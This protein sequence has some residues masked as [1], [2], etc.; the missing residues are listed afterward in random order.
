MTAPTSS[1]P[2]APGNTSGG[3]VQGGG[4]QGGGAPSTIGA[5]LVLLAELAGVDAKHRAISER[6]ESLPAAAR[7]ADDASS[8]LKKQLDDATAKKDAAEKARKAVETEIVDERA[9]MKKWE[10]RAQD[11]RGEREHAALVSEI[12][13]ARRV[14]SRLEDTQLEHM[15]AIEEATAVISAVAEQH[16][17]ASDDA[18]AEWAKVD[19]DLQKLKGEAAL[20]DTARQALLVKLPAPLV[21]RYETVAAKRQGVG[22]ALIQGDT[23]AC[24]KRTLPPQLCIQVRKG[25]VVEQCPSCSRFLVH[26]SMTAAAADGAAPTGGA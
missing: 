17:K 11:I 23:C 19:G 15:E 6:L 22:V 5:Q 9:K 20:L 16:K 4:V 8:A 14:I 12:G 3:G 2:D 13:T 18:R 10:A 25:A 7:K 26:E 1:R 21:K 24:C